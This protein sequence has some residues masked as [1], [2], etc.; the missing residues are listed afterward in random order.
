VTHPTGFDTSEPSVAAVTGSY[1]ASLGRYACRVMQQGHRQEIITGLKDATSALLLNFYKRSQ[2]KKPGAIIYYRD[3]VDQGQFAAV[4]QE[5]YMAIRNVR[6][7]SPAGRPGGV[8]GGGW[9][10]RCS[11]LLFCRCCCNAL[12][13]PML[14][15]T[16]SSPPTPHPTRPAPSWSPPT[17]PTSHSWWCRSVTPRACSPLIT[18][19]RTAPATRCPAP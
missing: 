3:G 5:E 19:G 8:A 4:L 9:Y 18:R 7:N 14:T 15:T 13:T 2:G 17:P 6:D 12:Q 11:L 1:D 10:Q 16:Q